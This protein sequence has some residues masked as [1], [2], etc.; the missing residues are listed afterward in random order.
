MK[1]EIKSTKDYSIFKEFSS[2]REVDPKHVNQLVKAIQEKNLLHIN[3]IIVDDAF[4]IIDGQHRLEAAK[5]LKLEIFYIQGS[6]DRKDISKINSFQ[7]NWNTMDYVNFYTVEKIDAYVRFSH[8]VNKYPEMAVSA[9]LS[10]SNIDGRRDIKELKNGFLNVGNIAHAE[11]VSDF[12]RLL[13][14]EFDYDFVFDSRFPLAISKAFESESFRPDLLITRIKE[15]PRSFTRCHTVKMYLQ[16]IEEIYNKNL[17]K[18]K[19]RLT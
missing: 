15:S 1:P 14:K 8:L 6:A 18:N 13:N 3:P 11:K 17:S 12:C 9:L 4:H 5:R 10:L 16:M 19:V 7:K 2:N